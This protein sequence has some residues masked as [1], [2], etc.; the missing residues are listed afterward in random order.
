MAEI[1]NLHEQVFVNALRS[2]MNGKA[3]ATVDSFSGWLLGGFGVASALLVSQYD[4]V[5]KHLAAST[6]QT[7]LFLFLSALGLGI[8][9][10]YIYVI[11]TAHSQ[12]SAIGRELGEKASEK[13][14]RLDF[15][16]ILTEMEKS[17]FAPAR[18]FVSRSFD[19][20]RKGDLVSSTRNFSR[21]FQI[22]SVLAVIQAILILIAIFKVASSFHA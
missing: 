18:W 13:S 2:E 7:F 6:I 12:G 1:P 4:S 19:K 9:Q 5:S 22:Q 10:K 15:E 3:S 14:I 21:L 17:T 20:L 8:V 11:V 16:V